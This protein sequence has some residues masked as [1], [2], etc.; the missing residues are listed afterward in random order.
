MSANNNPLDSQKNL[1]KFARIPQQAAKT[2]KSKF[3]RNPRNPRVENQN[4]FN[5]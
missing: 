2:L 4:S 3:C 1:N 5:F